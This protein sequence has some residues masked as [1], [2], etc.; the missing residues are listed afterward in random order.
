MLPSLIAQPTSSARV[1]CEDCA[2]EEHPYFFC[3]PNESDPM[4]RR[5]MKCTD[6]PLK[7]ASDNGYSPMKMNLPLCIDYDYN[8]FPFDRGAYLGSVTTQKNKEGIGLYRN[9]YP[10][11]LGDFSDPTNPLTRARDKWNSLCQSGSSSSGGSNCCVIIE[12]SVKPEHF[13]IDGKQ[14]I[15]NQFTNFA[16]GCDKNCND[17]KILL[18]FSDEFMDWRTIVNENGDTIYY[19]RRMIYTHDPMPDYAWDN[20]TEIDHCEVDDYSMYS[21]VLHELG[22]SLGFAHDGDADVDGNVCEN[23]DNL[24]APGADKKMI[25]EEFDLTEEDEC[26]FIKFYC[27]PSPTSVKEIIAGGDILISPNPTSSNVNI[28]FK[29]TE[30]SFIEIEIIDING[31][32]ISILFDDLIHTD[33]FSQGFD[34]S[35]ISNGHYFIKI[36]GEGGAHVQSLVI[37]R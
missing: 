15:A 29:L 4:K 8:S 28:S 13:D 21:V 11:D 1:S 25:G 18:N 10:F 32:R 2:G 17:E 23:W 12:W 37:N 6:D 3:N 19:P 27:C 16:N 36:T 24:M 31:K 22:H 9:L 33:Q 26:K 7:Y 20:N 35:G 5:V 30:A 34:V 14:A